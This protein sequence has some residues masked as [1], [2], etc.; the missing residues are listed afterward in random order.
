MQA[1]TQDSVTRRHTIVLGLKLLAGLMIIAA[2]VFIAGIWVPGLSDVAFFGILAASFGWIAGGVRIGALVVASL[3]VLGVV[4]TLLRG[5]TW[6]LALIL[7][8][9]G[10]LYGYAASRG[11]GKAVLQLP[12]LT[13][14]FILKPPT[15]FSDPPV[16]DAKYIVGV[17]VVMLV[18][19]LWAI[20]VLHLAAGTR[21][22]QHVEVRE[23]RVPLLYGTILGVLSAVVMI[24]G[25][26]T[27]L[28]T[29]WVWVTLTLYVLADPQQLYTP[30]KMWGRVLGTL[31]G[32]A[33]VSLLVLVGIP[34]NVLLILALPA[35]W[36]TLVFMVIGRPYWQ[37]ALFLTITVVFMGM[38][39]VNTLL[40]D[41]ERIGFTIVGAGLSILA[42]ILV[43]VIGYRRAGLSAPAPAPASDPAT[44]PVRKQD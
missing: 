28:K 34:D 40:L 27:D 29:H 21:T 5:Q 25:T 6:A 18:T 39:E 44:A 22:L 11:V 35:L 1:A 16:I 9:L 2:P 19:G 30:A 3:A 7:I 26:S 31:A 4:V 17:L 24:I 13:P 37:Y 33:V 36:L 15:L 41:A 20:L 8:G 32:F 38:A 14:Y 10:V 43:N 42:A 23:P 12:I